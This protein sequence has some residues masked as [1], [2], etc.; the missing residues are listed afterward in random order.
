MSISKVRNVSGLNELVNL[1]RRPKDRNRTVSKTITEQ[2]QLNMNPEPKGNQYKDCYRVMNPIYDHKTKNKSFLTVHKQLKLLGIENNEFFLLLLNPRLQGVDPFDKNLPPELAMM[3]IDECQLNIFYFLREVVR[4]PE[5]GAKTVRF[6]LD[7]GTLAALYCFANNQNFYLIKPRQTGK[8]V[9]I[10]AMMAWAFKFGITNGGFMF[11]ANNEK[12]A[13]ANLKRMKTYISN[14]PSYM[15]KMGTTSVDSSGKTIRKTNNI[16]SY[17]EPVTNNSASVSNCAIS[18]EAAEEIGR[19]D[20]HNFEFFDEAE[21]TSYIETIVQVSGMA[22]NTA[23]RNAIENGA[24]SCRIFASTP[25]DLSDKKKC[26]SALKLVYGEEGMNNGALMWDER[27]YDIPYPELKEMVDNKSAYHLIYIE[28]DYKQLGLG[29]RWFRDAVVNVGGNVNKVRR[30]ILLKRFSGNNESP[31]SEDDITELDENQEAPVFTKTIG[32]LYDV[33]FYV[34]E[35]D[36]KKNRVYFLAL[37][38]SDGTGSDNYALTVLDPYTLKTVA[39]FRSQYMSPKGCLEL[40][41]YLIYKYFPRGMIIIESNRN[42]L[43]LIDFFKESSLRHRIYASPEASMDKFINSDLLDEKGF[44]KEEIMRRKYYGVK[45]TTSSRDMMMSLLVDAVNFKKDIL[46][47][48]YVVDDIKNLVLKNGKIQ[49]A[50]GE[51]DDSIMSWCLA[52]YVYYYGERLE[53][54]GFR[55]G[56]LPDDIMEDDEF[57]RLQSLYSNPEIRKQF[58]TMY[59]FYVNEIKDKMEKEHNAQLSMTVEES[60]ADDIGSIKKLIAKEDP[61]YAESPNSPYVEDEWK[62]NIMEK[63]KSLNK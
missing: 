10:C 41:E 14:L 21:F 4:I 56:Q 20:T 55:R 50:A 23:S 34:K 44:L 12:N 37:D 3:I 36:I 49:A 38:P 48:K 51:H 24:Y 42:G 26:Q 18:Q 28:Y 43:T 7:R 6:K 46:T 57:V 63:W 45:T 5:Q 17:V 11:S 52:M 58:P 31:F 35:K 47:T 60:T 40:M 16:K 61:E 54:Y 53:R 29:E 13:K 33:L 9:G 59:N 8:S 22:F 62:L 19:G 25:G 30:E 32:K 15:A 2:S 1:A 39:E 27:F